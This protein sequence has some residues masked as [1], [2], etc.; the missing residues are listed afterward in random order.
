[1]SA[2]P[3]VDCHAHVFTATAPAV[4]GARYRPGYAASLSSW[5]AH[6]ARCG[7]THGVLVQPSFFGT[8]NAEMLAALAIDPSHLRGVAVLEATADEGLVE[9]LDRAGVRAVRLNLRGAQED[10][11]A[12]EPWQRL[13]ARVR[14]RGWHVEVLTD[15]GRIPAV[16]RSL[17][18]TPMRVVLDHMG[19]P[20]PADVDATFEAAAALA[21]THEVWVKLS[22]PYRLAGLDPA[23]LARRWLALLGDTRLVWG[24]DWPW[25]GHEAGRDYRGSLQALADWVGEP[26]ARSILWDNPARLYRFT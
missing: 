24:S 1:M 13:L 16:A 7:V 6:W 9:R 21:A 14:D 3:I 22:A 17:R 8:D 18:A 2:L 10:M 12:L 4:R 19:H 25:T 15:A 26:S 23:A 5:Q 11:Y 20:G